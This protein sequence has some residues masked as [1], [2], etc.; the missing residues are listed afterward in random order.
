MNKII[1]GEMQPS[2]KNLVFGFKVTQAWIITGSF[3]R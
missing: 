2:E 1:S 3:D